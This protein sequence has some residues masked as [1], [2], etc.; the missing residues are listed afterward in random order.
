M[1][2]PQTPVDCDDPIDPAMAKVRDLVA[3]WQEDPGA[4][5]DGAASVL[6]EI[7]A[8]LAGAA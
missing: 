2:T 3:T 8:L 7:A 6:E 4:F 1:T 5:P